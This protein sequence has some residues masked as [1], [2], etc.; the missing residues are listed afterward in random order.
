MTSLFDSLSP[1]RQLD[2][3]PEAPP[4]LDDRWRIIDIDFE[5]SGLQ[6]WNG[7]YI[8]GGAI[9]YMT[10]RG[11]KSQYLPFKHKGGGNLPE[12]QVKSFFAGLRGKHIRNLNTRFD[13]HHAYVWGVDFE[14]QGCTVTDVGHLAALLDDH[15][16]TFNLNALATDYL[17]KEKIGKELNAAKMAEY[18]A[19]EVAPRAIGD[20]QLVHE[21]YGVMFP[22]IQEQDLGPVLDL[23]NR[24]I[25]VTCEMERNGA[26]IEVELLEQWITECEREYTECLWAIYRSTGLKVN[27]ESS[28]DQKV[29]FEKLGIPLE[30]TK[31][32]APS[33]TDDILKVI[34]HPTIL[35]LR[36]A[37][38]L[39][40]LL[41]TY[42]HK[43]R[44]NVDSNGVLRYALH[45]L[46]AE[47]DEL[48]SGQAGTISGRYS[49]GEIQKGVGVN[50]QAVMK[51]EKQ[52]TSYGEGFL[53]RRLHRPASGLWLSADAE[54]IEYRIFAHHAKNEA[55][56]EAFQ[57]NPRMSFHKFIHAMLLP[58]L[59]KLTYRRCKDVNFMN[60]Y[61]GG[62]AKLAYMLGFI[63]ASQFTKLQDEFRAEDGS[64]RI[65]KTHPL[66]KD[67]LEIKQMY[68]REMPEVPELIELSKK[69]GASRGYVK[70]ILGRRTRF[71][72]KQR[73]HKALNGV[74][75]GSAADIMKQKLVEL[76]AERKS[77]QFLL[78][79]T[80][81][82]EVDGDIP[83]QEHA[84]KV[85]EI[86]DRQSFPSLRVPILWG[87][88]TG[89]NWME[90]SE[91]YRMGK[92]DK[93]GRRV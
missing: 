68:D 7:D 22:Q 38:K 14:A 8:I 50:I 85:G 46:R 2:W 91:E 13:I 6:W 10:D 84:K 78:R 34:E 62:V 9:G 58:K 23:E 30:H 15:R 36:R 89:Q 83:D 76:H 81:H 60:I 4:T 24:L 92:I 69:I 66:L 71:P 51:I 27:P 90:C 77:T 12:P 86:L 43:Y 63:T 57:K 32:G 21:L 52:L 17:G 64:V 61:G 70:T 72:Q 74:I 80:V 67:A 53:I 5:T 42:L 18:H 44:K 55:I 88:E 54:Q 87:V 28:K 59:P 39:S 20:V 49:S 3:H 41:S 73:L 1:E 79:Y 16:K 82:D 19:G 25:Y 33:F 93:Q 26:P 29:L 11:Y 65:P 37:K 35:L 31:K 75:Q 56:L 45:Q 40:T 48:D 47:K